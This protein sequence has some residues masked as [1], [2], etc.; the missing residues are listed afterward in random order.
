MVRPRRCV[1]DVDTALRASAYSGKKKPKSAGGKDDEKK[2]RK[3]EPFDPVAAH[4]KERADA[5]SMWL[6]IV[7]GLGIGMLMRYVLM[8]TL[9]G[10]ETILWL[11]P[12]LLIA[13]LPPLHKVLIPGELS[14][15]F[16]KINWF[17]ASFLFIFTWLAIS[18]ILVN[19]PY[20]DIAPPTFAGGLDVE[21]TDGVVDAKWRG[22][23]YTL[24]LDRGSVDVVLGFAV[25]DN[26]DAEGA[27]IEVSLWQ[28]GA[29]VRELASGTAAGQTDAIADFDTVESWFRGNAVAPHAL[30]I[31][32][33]YDLGTLTPGE[34]E[35]RV[36]LSEEGD[37]WTSNDWDRVYT[38]V[39][40]QVAT[41]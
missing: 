11:I 27:E 12:L 33:S 8:P 35:V 6:V 22:G 19:P 4:L 32:M 1:V 28:Y 14:A 31:G 21:V 18:F 38:I 30:D 26:V 20:A 16:D 36:H 7:Y 23:V 25:R 39:I 3:L 24:G 2:S 40:A 37:P 29:M 10:P 41:A 5:W 13:T 34:Y 9:T 17:R 15:L